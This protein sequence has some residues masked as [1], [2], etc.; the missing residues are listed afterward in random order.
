ME[1]HTIAF[2]EAVFSSAK[3]LPR[4]RNLTAQGI[5]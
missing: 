1:L 4:V 5:I 3:V 2:A